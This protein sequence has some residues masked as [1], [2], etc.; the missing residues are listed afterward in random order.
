MNDPSGPD[1]YAGR[2]RVMRILHA[3]LCLGVLFFLGIVL[4]LAPLIKPPPEVPLISY[5]IAGFAVVSC[6]LAWLMPTVG[7]PSAR[8]RQTT[9][10]PD[11]D[12]DRWWELYQ[13]RLILRC[14]PLEGGAFAQ[15]IAYLLEGQPF[16]LGLGVALFLLLAV[17]FPTRERVERW[18]EVQEDLARQARW[19]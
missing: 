6:A 16:I 9:D 17:Q 12:R 1:P 11:S 13:T 4:A 5:V 14:A 18:V 15:L 3:A 10:Q 7:T 2:L 8:R 19:G